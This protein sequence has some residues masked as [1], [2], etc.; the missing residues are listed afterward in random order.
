MFHGEAF[1]FGKFQNNQMSSRNQYPVHFFQPLVQVFK[2]PYAECYGNG[3]E[4]IVGKAQAGAVFFG[5][6]DL[7]VQSG[8]LHFFASYIH[9]PFRDIYTDQCLGL[10]GPTGLDGEITSSGSYVHHALRMERFQ[11]MDGFFPPTFV[12]AEREQ[13]VQVVVGRSD[14]VEHFF[15]LFGFA[16][17][18]VIGLDVFLRIAGHRLM[19][20]VSCRQRLKASFERMLSIG[21]PAMFRIILSGSLLRSFRY[22]Q[23]C[24]LCR[25]L[26]KTHR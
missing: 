16:F 6:R 19:G 7:F 26:R 25:L 4:A 22:V 12:D 11:A 13:M 9:H 3:I 23:R 21:L 5:K 15:Y 17:F 14:V 18:G 1:R 8:C 2:I 10:E 20:G 24:G